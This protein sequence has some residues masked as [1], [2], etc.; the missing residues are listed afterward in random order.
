MVW[1]DPDRSE[2]KEKNGSGTQGVGD[3]PTAS[4]FKGSHEIPYLVLVF[5]FS[6]DPS[7]NG[8]L[9]DYNY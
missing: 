1:T 9:H 2:T 4:I 3:L 7:L 8:G 6:V 5:L